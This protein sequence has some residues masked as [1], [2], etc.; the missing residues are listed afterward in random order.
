LIREISAADLKDRLQSAEDAP[1]LLDVREVQEFAYC[2][3]DGAVSIPLGELSRRAHELPA[4]REIVAICHHGTR[5]L[6][7]AAFLSHALALDVM[8]LQGGVAA[9]AREVDPSMKQ[10]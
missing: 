1:F 5:S 7:A 10:Y 2:R 4:G 3:I 6:Q 8:N 9:W